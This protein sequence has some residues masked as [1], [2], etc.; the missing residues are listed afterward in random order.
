MTI[1]PFQKSL[2]TLCSLLL[3][4][5]VLTPLASANETSS[6]E[7]KLA[8]DLEYIFDVAAKKENGKYILNE[9]MIIEKFGKSSLPSIQAFIKMANDE[10][11]TE[12]DLV[13]IQKPTNSS[14]SPVMQMASDESYTSCVTNQI[15][16][17][18][19]IGFITGGMTELIDQ[20][21]WKELSKEIIKLAGKTAIKGGAVGLAASLAWF[22]VRCI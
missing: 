20:K 6:E 11:L 13:G 4:F 22:S 8:S 14:D 9:E 2:L 7:Q 19:G 21:A 18:T 1:K 16:D 10:T 15:I 5:T 17:F 3:I 12:N